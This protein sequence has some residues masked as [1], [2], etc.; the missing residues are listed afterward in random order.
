MSPRCRQDVV[1][2]S[3]GFRQVLAKKRAGAA[4][5]FDDKF[6]DKLATSLEIV[7]IDSC[8]PR[9]QRCRP[10]TS[11]RCRE[12]VGDVFQFCAQKMTPKLG[13]KFRQVG[14]KLTTS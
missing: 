2:M 8:G 3:P 4:D 10:P 1:K 14:D 6:D 9:G 12:D 13:D 11:R 5:K 7:E